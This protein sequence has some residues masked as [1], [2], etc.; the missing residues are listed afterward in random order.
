MATPK[1]KQGAKA[2]DNCHGW[3]REIA[4][5]KEVRKEEPGRRL[6]EGDT[7]SE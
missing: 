5:I 4:H 1:H 3:K 6:T 2:I 7:S